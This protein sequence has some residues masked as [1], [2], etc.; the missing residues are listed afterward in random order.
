M[1][2]LEYNIYDSVLTLKIYKGLRYI[3]N[4]R[5]SYWLNN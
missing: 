5:V 4:I 3:A 1:D 2:L